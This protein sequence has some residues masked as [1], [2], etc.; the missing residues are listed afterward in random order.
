MTS[1][2][3]IYQSKSVISHGL[4]LS[5]YDLLKQLLGIIKNIV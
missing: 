1:Y 3:S 5:D 2:N 4:T